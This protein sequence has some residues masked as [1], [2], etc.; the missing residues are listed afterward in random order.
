MPSLLSD[1]SLLQDYF[2]K[3]FLG[4]ISKFIPLAE[5]MF[6]GFQALRGRDSTILRVLLCRQPLLCYAVPSVLQ[7]KY[8]LA[9][10]C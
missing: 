5:E 10:D 1:L 9:S 3:S 2:K 6:Q 8:L 4:I 7:A